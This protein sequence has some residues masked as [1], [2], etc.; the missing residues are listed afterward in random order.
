MIF[1]VFLFFSNYLRFAQIVGKENRI[2][3]EANRTIE[4]SAIV[5]Q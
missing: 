3:E 2:Y 5:V 1:C 4:T